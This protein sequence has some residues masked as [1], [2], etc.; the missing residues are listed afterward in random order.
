VELK[1]Q[2]VT[3]GPPPSAQL[4]GQAKARSPQD[5]QAF[6]GTTRAASIDIVSPDPAIRWRA[7]GYGVV[8]RSADG[9]VTWVAQESGTTLDFTAGSSPAR[10]V[11]WLIGRGGVVL[12]S[13]D[14]KT[15]TQRPFPEPVDLALVSATDA[16]TAT[17]TTSDGR[18]FSTTDGGATWSRPPP[19][20]FPA[21]PF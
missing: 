9:G 13:I 11:C 18:R 7:F 10:D 16:K 3:S 2:E 19:Q 12:L 14:G 4:A 5:A 17:V 1:P 21:A 6:L 8:R 20:E 15:W